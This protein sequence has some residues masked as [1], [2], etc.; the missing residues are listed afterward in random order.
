MPQL[1]SKLAIGRKVYDNHLAKHVKTCNAT[2]AG[3]VGPRRRRGTFTLNDPSP[4]EATPDNTQKHDQSDAI[5]ELD[6]ACRQRSRAFV[7]ALEERI[8]TYREQH[9]PKPPVI[10]AYVEVP[11]PS[12]GE[13]LPKPFHTGTISTTVIR[14][15]LAD[16]DTVIMRGNKQL[17]ADY[18]FDF[19]SVPPENGG[20]L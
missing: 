19:L 10:S 4:G 6:A 20:G 14:E 9:P 12:Q 11:D 13:A 3:A 15:A 7:E 5:A 16:A 2:D 18:G 8:R 17:L 1:Y